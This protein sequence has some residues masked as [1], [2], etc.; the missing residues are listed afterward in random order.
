MENQNQIQSKNKNLILVIFW[1]YTFIHFSFLTYLFIDYQLWKKHKKILKF[2]SIPF[3]IAILFLLTAIY[4]TINYRSNRYSLKICLIPSIINEIILSGLLSICILIVANS[5]WLFSDKDLIYI[6]I[7]F[8]IESS[9][10]IILFIHI[11]IETRKKNTP[12]TSNIE[13]VDN[14]PILNNN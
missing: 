4:V 8:L 6:I 7:I 14:N 3:I 9:P 13:N 10:N 2:L 11:F 1:I 5:G 12:N